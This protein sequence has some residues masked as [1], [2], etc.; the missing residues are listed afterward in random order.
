VKDTG[1]I[2]PTKL[3][4]IMKAIIKLK[5][6]EEKCNKKDYFRQNLSSLK[7]F[8]S[9][10]ITVPQTATMQPAL[11]SRQERGRN[12]NTKASSFDMG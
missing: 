9:Y 6:V 1:G 8:F 11:V 7:I 10:R 5:F 12:K 3:I 2:G 4:L